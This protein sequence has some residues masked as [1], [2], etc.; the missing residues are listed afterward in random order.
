MC[1]FIND[2]TLGSCMMG[3]HISFFTLS[4]STWTSLSVHSEPDAE[5]QPT[6]LHDLMT[7]I[8]WVLAVGTLKDFGA[9]SADQWLRNITSTSMEC[10][11]GDSRETSNFR[12]SAH[13]CVRRR[14]ESYVEMLGN[15]TEHLL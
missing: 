6:G 3:H 11:S 13:L 10:L 14:A 2:N 1:L 5:A 8:L 12:Q 4:E 9:F 15:H 7:L